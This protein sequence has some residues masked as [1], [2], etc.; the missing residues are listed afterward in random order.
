MYFINALIPE[1]KSGL[2]QIHCC[3]VATG[4]FWNVFYEPDTWEEVIETIKVALY[5]EEKDSNYVSTIFKNN[6]PIWKTKYPH[7]NSYKTLNENII[8]QKIRQYEL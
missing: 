7:D 8:E 2:Y 1:S 6:N 5:G 3:T 4:L